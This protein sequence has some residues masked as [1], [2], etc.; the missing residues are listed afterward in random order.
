MNSDCLRQ[1]LIELGLIGWLYFYQN[2]AYA[3]KRG[4]LLLRVEPVLH[5]Q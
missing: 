4:F 3:S 1:L 2:P 5:E